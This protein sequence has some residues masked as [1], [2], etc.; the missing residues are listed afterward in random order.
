MSIGTM[1]GTGEDDRIRVKFQVWICLDWD[2]Y[3]MIHR[4]A[5]ESYIHGRPEFKGETG[6]GDTLSGISAHR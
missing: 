2:A 4:D 3:Q 1:Y 5:V 6:A